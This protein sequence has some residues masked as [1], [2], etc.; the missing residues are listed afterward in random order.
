MSRFGTI[1]VAFCGLVFAFGCLVFD[2]AAGDK[3]LAL[4]I[5]LYGLPLGAQLFN[6]PTIR[7]YGTWLSIFL[8]A[9]ALCL[10]EYFASDYQ[11][12]PPNMDKLSDSRGLR[13]ISGYPRLSTDEKGFRVTKDIN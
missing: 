11:T 10:P 13:G 9:Q 5:G 6:N 4:T 8:V 12:L 3:W 1:R 2:S 7:A